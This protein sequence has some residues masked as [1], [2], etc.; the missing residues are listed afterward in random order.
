MQSLDAPSATII[1]I[2]RAK[3]AYDAMPA[4]DEARRRMWTCPG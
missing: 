4:L 3:M 2:P 1:K